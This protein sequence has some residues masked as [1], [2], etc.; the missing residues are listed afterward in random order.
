MEGRSM[1]D[2]MPWWGLLF[3]AAMAFVFTLPISIITATTNQTPGLNIITET[4][5]EDPSKIN[6]LSSVHRNNPRWNY[7]YY[8]GMVAIDLH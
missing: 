2:F 3:A 6:V 7:Q 4:L 8:S 1:I 5:H